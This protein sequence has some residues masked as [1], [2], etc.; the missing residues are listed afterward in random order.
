MLGLF[1]KSEKTYVQKNFGKG[2]NNVLLYEEKEK[3]T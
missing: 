3:I 2:A 1:F